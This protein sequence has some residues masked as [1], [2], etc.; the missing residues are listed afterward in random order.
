MA[1]PEHVAILK[2]GVRTWNKWRKDNPF[3]TPDLSKENLS[4]ET[5]NKRYYDPTKSIVEYLLEPYLSKVDFNRTNLFE[6]NFTGA[7]L[8]RANLNGAN[9]RSAILV[10]ANLSEATL[11]EA[12]LS[13]VIGTKAELSEANLSGANLFRGNFVR[14]YFVGTNLIGSKLAEANL[15]EANLGGADLNT[16]DLSKA[17]LQEANLSMANLTAACLIGT[18]LRGINLMGANLTQADL[19]NSDLA[20]ATL[21]RAILV[22]TV[23]EG[24]QLTNC[25]IYGISAWNV[26]LKSANQ[27]DFVITR[28]DEPEITVDNL[29]VAQ[30]IYL[31]LNNTEIRS[32]IDTITS[33]A[34]LILGRFR[35]ERKAV[36]NAIR[37][38]LRKRD[39]LPIVFD[40]DK[41][42]NRD[43]TET[44]I[45]LAGMSRFV[46]ADLS[47]PHS[48]PHE[49]MSFVEKLPSVPVKPIFCPV[50]AHPKP[51]PMLEHFKHYHWVLGIFQY[52]DL[53]H[54]LPALADQ[55]IAPAEAKV[56]ELR[57][58][59]T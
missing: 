45:T 56:K 40:F 49:L 3:I 48:I 52:N 1:N 35:E 25:R 30:F 32:V 20:E 19:T 44:I 13:D 47:D 8:T 16:V 18:N 9:L 53:A 12:D 55:V 28:G 26:N 22:D 15:S 42:T 14:A 58:G 39:Y 11:I 5:F 41:P 21:E 37:D 10:Q 7:N 2:Q 57:S 43:L 31:L 17:N 51:Y 23:L 4:S 50:D 36:L 6:V 38:E 59:T 29:Q 33:K 54:L 46:I 27:S 34:V 24:S